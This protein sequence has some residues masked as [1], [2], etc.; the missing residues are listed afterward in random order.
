MY[1]VYKDCVIFV[2]AFAEY[3]LDGLEISNHLDDIDAIHTRY[4]VLLWDYGKKKQSQC[5]VSEDESTG[6]LLKKK[7]GLFLFCVD[8]LRDSYYE[9]LCRILYVLALLGQYLLRKDDCQMY[10]I[11]SLAHLRS[12]GEK[13]RQDNSTRSTPK[14]GNASLMQQV[15]QFPL[16]CSCLVHRVLLV[17][18]ICSSGYTMIIVIVVMG[19]GYVWWKAMKRH[20]ISRIDR[21]D[22]KIDDCVDNTAATRD[23][24]SEIRGKVRTFG[25]N[26]QSVHLVVQSL[27]RSFIHQHFHMYFVF[28]ILPIKLPSYTEARFDCLA[29]LKTTFFLNE[30]ETK[31]RRNEGRQ[32][33]TNYGVGKLVAFVRSIIETSR[34]KE[35]IEAPPSSSSRAALELPSV[36]SS[37]QRPL[38]G[39]VSA[40]GLKELGGISDV[41]EVSRESSPQ[42]SGRSQSKLS[43]DITLTWSFSKFLGSKVLFMFDLRRTRPKLLQVKKKTGITVA[44]IFCNSI[45]LRSV[46][47]MGTQANGSQPATN[48]STSTIN[49]GFEEFTLDPSHP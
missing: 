35:Q 47:V 45:F 33:E 31:I 4:D 30:Q 46:S 20:L 38:H 36:A 48:S 32:N 16:A 12:R 26:V 40:S 39:A 1:Y 42:V 11:F 9:M 19:Y 37:A 5:A 41:V 7:D 49:R 27:E 28:F 29:E 25:E 6:R 43:S 13:I 17:F 14:S 10:L 8:T 22:S 23:E 2:A 24:V 3:L 21:V 15:W 18:G 34:A 44:C